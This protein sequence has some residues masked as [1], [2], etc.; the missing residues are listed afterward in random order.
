MATTGYESTRLSEETK[1]ELHALGGR[2]DSY[3]D[4]I[5]EL[6]ALRQ[7]VENHD[8]NDLSEYGFDGFSP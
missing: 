8:E 6:L 3:D 4:T 5:R 2:K 7:A 1:E